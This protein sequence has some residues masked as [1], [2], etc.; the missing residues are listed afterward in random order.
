MTFSPGDTG[1][2]SWSIGM[3]V[4][5]DSIYRM[6]DATGSKCLNMECDASGTDNFNYRIT[7]SSNE[8][9]PCEKVTCKQCGYSWEIRLSYGK[10]L[11][12]RDASSGVVDFPSKAKGSGGRAI[13]FE[14][15]GSV[16]RDFY[17]TAGHL[18]DLFKYAEKTNGFENIR[19]KAEV[20]AHLDS[21]IPRY[22]REEIPGDTSN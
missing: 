9:L 22:Y 15:S 2:F 19:K 12:V 13:R 21:R 20:L 7:H 16:V 5:E 11:Y 6:L 10:L 8:D 18:L 1:A 14:F 3:P 17:R 4:T